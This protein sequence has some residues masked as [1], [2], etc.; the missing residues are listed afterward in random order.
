M[1]EI[2]VDCVESVR[3]AGWGG[4]DRV[5][6]CSAL[7]EGGTTPSAGMI[8]TVRE[9]FAGRLMV[10]IRPRGH[11][12][13]FDA[14]ELL[15][16]RSDILHSRNAG[17]DGVVIGCLRADGTVDRE[18]CARLLEAAEGMDV[19]FHRAIDMTRDPIEALEDVMSLG[20][21]RILT[22][23][24]AVS[25]AAGV[26]VIRR[27]VLRAGADAVIMP[28]GGLHAGNVTAVIH[29]TGATEIHLSARRDA[30]SGMLHRNP[31][32]FMGS[33]TRGIEYQRRVT[34]ADEVRRCAEILGR[35]QNRQA[36]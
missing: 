19:T 21:R 9:A 35:S 29:T 2:C 14:D 36:P 6:L 26:G 10:I 33:F 5:E 3:A 8:E 31:E 34:C 22:S 28:G 15:A 16:M 20:I 11:D 32:V 23:G 30:A 4:A 25:A 24:A 17:A 27:M 18:S 7:P 13:L 12:F 1:L